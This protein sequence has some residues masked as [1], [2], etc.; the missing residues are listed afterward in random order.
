M[1][2]YAYVFGAMASVFFG[3][4]PIFSKGLSLAGMDA[5]SII[6]SGHAIGCLLV[7][8]IC[9]AG[10]VNIRIPLSNAAMYMVT[11]AVGM[12]VTGMLLNLSYRYISVGTATAVHFLYPS[13]VMVIEAL[14]MK[15]RLNPLQLSAITSSILG[16]VLLSS[17]TLTISPMGIYLA[18]ASSLTYSMY[19]LTGRLYVKKEVHVLAKL[20]YNYLGSA[21][22]CFILCV[23]SGGPDIYQGQMH[24][25]AAFA[26]VN[27]FA[28]LLLNMAIRYGSVSKV[29]FATLFEPL[30]A[31]VLSLVIYGEQLNTTTLCG[32]ALILFS[33]W[34]RGKSSEA[35]EPHKA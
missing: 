24:N 5:Q 12:G 16:M 34:I 31:T 10:K 2:G 15:S 4:G 19:L 3:I 21:M 35:A 29:A 26:A 9:L 30:T 23:L 32:F 11:G 7:F 14:C 28:Y 6:F 22:L 20:M 17:G 18:L 13:I 1:K 25:L 33:I 8:F 27:I